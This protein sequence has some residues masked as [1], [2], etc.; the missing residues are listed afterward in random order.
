[1]ARGGGSFLAPISNYAPP[2][3]SVSSNPDGSTR[4]GSTHGTA[5][6]DTIGDPNADPAESRTWPAKPRHGSATKGHAATNADAAAVTAY[7]SVAAG[8]TGAG[9]RRSDEKQLS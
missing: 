2:P 3:A 8:G 5:G 9:G 7:T 4:F 1:M 6:A